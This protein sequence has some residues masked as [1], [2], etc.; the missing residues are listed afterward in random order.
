MSASDPLRV[1]L[2]ED[3]PDDAEL[4][5]RELTRGGVD[6]V[7]Q[8]VDT[9][10]EMTTALKGEPW[11]FIVSDYAMPQFSAPEAFAV[12]KKSG[13]DIPFVIVSGTVGEEIAVQAMKLGVHDYL[14]KGNL[15]R[16]VP[17]FERELRERDGRRARREAEAALRR[18]EDQLRHA[19]KLE[20]V[21]R[22]AGGIAHDFNNLLTVILSYTSLM[23]T[24][25]QETDP[26]LADLEEIRKASERASALTRQLLAFGRQQMRDP[27]VLNLNQVLLAIE[28]MLR[29]LIGEDVELSLLVG[30]PLGKIHVDQ[31]QIEQIIMNL[32]VNARDAMPHGGKLTLETSNVT[33]DPEYA[34][35]HI[36]VVPGPHVVL[37]ATDTG[38]GM[39]R[40]TLTRIFEPFFTT[41]ELGK[42]TG[43]GLSTVYGIV[44]QSQG[45]IWV[46]SVPG[47]GTTFRIYFP[48]TEKS[49]EAQATKAPPPATLQGHET[50]LLVE[51]EEQVRVIM[52]SVLRRNGYN[53]L[54]AQN[55]G[56]AFLICEKYA[57]K[58]DLLVTDV[59]MPRMSGRELA[60]RLVPMRPGIKVLYMSGY[61][62]GTALQAGA[63]DSGVAFLQKPVLPETLARKVREV[64]D[65]PK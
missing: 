56:E 62:E 9:R 22:L 24:G 21:G 27:R 2:V 45:H 5:M 42:G 15:K 34:A 4:V 26:M 46:D 40:A 33:L 65:A 14:L 47:T 28:Q 8:R 1:L 63:L 39:D 37:T 20:A 29:R 19:Q 54:E 57:A 18:T 10:D 12:L 61:T 51:D 58:I 17:A 43:L 49:E 23:Q 3:S 31:G 7:F 35:Q 16:L 11:D 60:E 36:G 53:V 48:C 52:R 55:G 13:L 25:L 6:A 38:T 50:I 59:V 44:K 41:K 32:A 30:H 64:L